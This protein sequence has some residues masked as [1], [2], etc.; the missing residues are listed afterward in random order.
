VAAI[1][2]KFGFNARP[3]YESARAVPRMQLKLG[4]DAATDAE[5]LGTSVRSCAAG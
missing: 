2:Q 3:Q 1:K 5:G 4:W